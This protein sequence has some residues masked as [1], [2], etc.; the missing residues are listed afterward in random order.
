MSS[1]SLHAIV[2]GAIAIAPIVEAVES[3]ARGTGDGCGAIAVFAGVV[4]GSHAGRRVRS[5][6]YEAF[7]P[8]ALKTF[9]RIEA[10][11]TAQWPGAALAIHHRVGRLEVGEI[12]VAIVAGTAHRAE[13]FQVTRYAIERVKQVVPIWK[14]ESFE[15]GEAWVDGACADVDDAAAR[16]AALERACA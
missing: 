6:E 14:R 10:E 13:A 15:D 2:R 8:L 16:K 9:A 11:A 1:A 5:L 4:R 7:E 12:S 3:R